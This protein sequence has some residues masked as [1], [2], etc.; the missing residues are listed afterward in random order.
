MVGSLDT[1]KTVASSGIGRNPFR[2]IEMQ[3]IME[4]K[5]QALDHCDVISVSGQL[6]RSSTAQLTE[7]LET[8]N[9]RGKYNLI[10][11]LSQVKYISSMGFRALL[12]AQQNNRRNHR[13][14][15]ILTQVPE[16][17]HQA[18]ELTGFSEFF[19]IFEDLSSAITF[20]AQLLYDPT[21]DPSPPQKTKSR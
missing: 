19:N 3:E 14:E 1:K 6:E 17:I 18:L 20:A 9:K 16:H 21:T 7:V 13:G 4:I 12:M 2:V 5:V 11:E 15:L 10:I 8:S